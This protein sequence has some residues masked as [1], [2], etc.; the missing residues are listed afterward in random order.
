[1]V[2][3]GTL[4]KAPHGGR[5]PRAQQSGKQ[6]QSLQVQS[7]QPWPGRDMGPALARG[8]GRMGDVVGHRARFLRCRPWVEGG[9]SAQPPSS[10]FALGVFSQHGGRCGSRSISPRGGPQPCPWPSSLFLCLLIPWVVSRPPAP[11][12]RPLLFF[13]ARPP[14]ATSSASRL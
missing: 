1:M 8:R 10:G 7:R 4:G 12:C 5:R 2:T 13:P 9:V 6:P 3:A 11:A 14:W